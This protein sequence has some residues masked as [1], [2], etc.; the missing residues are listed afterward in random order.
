[1]AHIKRLL[2]TFDLVFISEP[3]IKDAEL[4]LVQ[5]RG[6]MLIPSLHKEEDGVPAYGGLL[7]YVANR[8]ATKVVIRE[9]NHLSYRDVIILILGDFTFV[10]A[11]I[12]PVNSRFLEQLDVTPMEYL[13]GLAVYTDYLCI[14]GDLNLHMG[15]SME[16]DRLDARG[17]QMWDIMEG[18]NL[19][20][21]NGSKEGN[22]GFTFCRGV[23]VSVLD[24]AFVSDGYNGELEFT[25]GLLQAES[26]HCPISLTLKVQHAPE[27][28]DRLPYAE[29]QECKVPQEDVE[30]GKELDLAL[31]E[32]QRKRSEEPEGDT[33]GGRRNIEV[34]F[35]QPQDNKTRLAIRRK[36][37]KLSAMEGFAT[38]TEVKLEWK[39]L[40]NKLTAM[41]RKAKQNTQY[42]NHQQLMQAR[43][44][45]HYWRALRDV[46][47]ERAASIPIK[48]SVI[49]AHFE[50]LLSLEMDSEEFRENYR[51]EIRRVLE[52]VEGPM[53]DVLNDPITS[54][55]ISWEITQME[56]SAN[57]EDELT[58]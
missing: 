49:S 19:R 39:A 54:M 58:V 15:F 52:G 51:D 42:H 38:N 37:N 46:Y 21:M 13:S 40:R 56:A 33:S 20:M 17:Q 16:D 22:G 4:N 9:Q 36:M 29:P 44:N 1:M 23:T 18:H 41:R 48:S 34:S 32:M 47:K 30:I 27:E 24:Y 31:K 45:K 8:W 10:A 11:Y 12:P 14:M 53:V 35:I 2:S 7:V 55:E 57:G 28:A 3:W 5:L 50:K 25:V 26:D 6:F 43:G